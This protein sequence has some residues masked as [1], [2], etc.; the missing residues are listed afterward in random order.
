MDRVVFAHQSGED[1]HL[2]WRRRGVGSVQDDR[3]RTHAGLRRPPPRHRGALGTPL[4]L[5]ARGPFTHAG[6]AT[7]YFSGRDL[8]WTCIAAQ[9]LFPSLVSSTSAVA[10]RGELL[11][12]APARG[13]TCARRR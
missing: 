1:A 12:Q 2:A 13:G 6:Q 5:R 3:G 9:K 8:T 4:L 11:G 10:D 7:G